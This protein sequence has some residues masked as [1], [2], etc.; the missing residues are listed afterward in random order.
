[1]AENTAFFSIKVD[2]ADKLEANLTRLTQRGNELKNTKKALTDQ[3]KNLDQASKTYAADTTALNGKLAQVNIKLKENNTE[4]NKNQKEYIDSSNAIKSSSGSLIEIRIQLK[5]ATA[6]YDRLSKSQR[7][8]SKIGGLQRKKIQEL[9]ASLVQMEGATGRNQRSVG[10]YGQA[11]TGILPMMGGFG[12]QLSFMVGQLGAIKTALGG[13]ALGQNAVATST[14]LSSKALRGFRVALIATGIGAI[15]VLVGTLIAAF[16]STQ[17]GMD[18]ITKVTRPLG[19]VFGKLFGVIQDVG[20]AVMDAIVLAVSKPGIAFQNMIDAFSS[21]FKFLKTV[22]LD[23]M[24]SAYT[25]LALGIAQNFLKMRI[26]FNDFTG[27]AS[28]SK[29]LTKSLDAVNQKIEENVAIIK[30]GADTVKNVVQSVADA[31]NGA[32]EGMSKAIQLGERIDAL[33]KQIE[34]QEINNLTIQAKLRVEREKQLK[35][36]KDQTKTDAERLF[37]LN[38][39]EKAQNELLSSREAILKKRI[40]LKKEE[41]SVNDTSREELKELAQ[42]E[43]DLILLQAENEKKSATI[44]AQR[45]AIQIRAIN[46]KTAA[47]KK[48]DQEILKQN[49]TLSSEIEKL[50]EQALLR[51]ITNK[52]QAELKKL[53]IEK[54][55]RVKGLEA[56]LQDEKK[57][58][59]KELEAIKLSNG[60][61]NEL[62]TLLNNEFKASQN[63]IKEEDKVLEDEKETEENTTKF[64][65]KLTLASNISKGIT[66]ELTKRVGREKEIEINALNEKLQTGNITQEQFDKKKL[67]IEKKAFNK[68][69]AL[70]IANVGIA[71][72]TQIANIQANAAANP[73]NAVTAGL[74][75]LTQAATLTAIA[76]GTSAVS[77]GMIA[78]KKFERGGVLEGSSHSNGGIPF[79]IDGRSGFEAEGGETLINKESSRRFAPLLSQINQAG[80]GVSL[81][82]PNASTLSKFANG[83]VLS[84]GKMSLDNNGLSEEIIK[85]VTTAINTI[86]IV[87]VSEETTSQSNRVKQIEQIN[88]F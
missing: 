74:A 46:K 40:T 23:P 27:D 33:T 48:A 7:N 55:F 26:A 17:R 82:Y 80:G 67:E 3:L 44:V 76:V 58:S 87:N 2:G 62:I 88:T 50:E 37:A 5:K 43:A 29:K 38:L 9:N 22:I 79:T 85:G 10:N 86:K 64:Q 57:A 6:T 18:A 4:L 24:L 32:I 49:Q 81:A 69:K 61:K 8:N 34:I 63:L 65:Q 28:E 54:D 51:G 70:Q 59:G 36:S 83:G 78:A 35:I 84:G 21:G 56:S 15:V 45:S 77:V 39:G 13:A 11:V 66:S 30:K 1:M 60:K 41:Q 47:Q 72:A 16:A 14:S 19:V 71:L 31:T 25:L 75:G 53:E 12:S 68:N 20:L 73:A 52:E 42:L